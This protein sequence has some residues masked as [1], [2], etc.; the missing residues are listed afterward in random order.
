M[1]AYPRLVR[2]LHCRNTAFTLVELLVVMGIV[3]V[4]SAVA[5]P[6]YSRAR[7]R[8]LSVKCLSNLRQMGSA[9]MVYAGEH[10]MTLP[11][12]SH[13]V[14][15]GGKS[16]TLT[17]QDYA[18]GKIVFRCPCDENKTRTYT[19]VINDFLT[20]NPAGASSLDFSCLVR[21]ESPAQTVLFAEA[22]ATYTNSDHFHFAEYYGGR[23]PASDFASQVAVQRHLGAAN[24]VFADGHMEALTWPAVQALLAK[25][26]GH[27]VDPTTR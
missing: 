3:A 11:V 17:L 16:W 18:G 2:R 27:F 8:T 6:V 21:I 20:P 25:T 7:Q 5:V 24:Y 23:V 10:N 13:Q 12:T 1:S 19:Y 22:S 15:Q 4:L 26:D 14:Q 9:A